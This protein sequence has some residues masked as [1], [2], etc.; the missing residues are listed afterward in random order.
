MYSTTT[1]RSC[2]AEERRD[3]VRGR[4][5][6]LVRLGTAQP[7]DSLIVLGSGLFTVALALGVL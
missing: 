7:Y 1:W 5:Y 2:S 4:W 6:N 3:V